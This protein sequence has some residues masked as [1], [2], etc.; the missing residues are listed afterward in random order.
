MNETKLSEVTVVKPTDEMLEELG[1]FNWPIWE[2][3]KSNFPWH[4]DAAETCYL[5][6]GRVTVTP[7]GGDEVT[8]GAGDLVTFPARMSCFWEI[9]ED[10]RKHYTFG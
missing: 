4:Y 3:E 7:A 5:L 2:K 1:V 6:K 8:F 9:H 10:V